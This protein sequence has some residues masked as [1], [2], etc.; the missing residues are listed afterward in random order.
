MAAL[1]DGEH[2]ERQRPEEVQIFAQVGEETTRTRNLRTLEEN[3]EW[4][5]D[6][7]E[8]GAW[9]DIG[10]FFPYGRG[11]IVLSAELMRRVGDRALKLDFD[12]RFLVYA[13]TVRL[14]QPLQKRA[15]WNEYRIP[16]LA[17][18]GLELGDSLC[19]RRAPIDWKNVQA[20]IPSEVRGGV[21][22]L[23]WDSAS[24][25]GG[26]E[27]PGEV[28]QRLAAAKLDLLIS[29]ALPLPG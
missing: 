19:W 8:V 5:L 12:A 20:A 26:P 24:G 29:F 6:R 1:D 15:A 4:A 28:L 10:L 13:D 23:Q 3:L 2:K 21:A 25:F 11:E 16:S 14:V 7:A 17:R 27:L 18:F 22:K 9:I